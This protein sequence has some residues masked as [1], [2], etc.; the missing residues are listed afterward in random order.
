MHRLKVF[1]S[2]LALA[3][4]VPAGAFAQVDT[5]DAD[6]SRY[7]ALGDS[8]TAGFASAALVETF[9]RNSYP[10]LIERQATGS[11]AGFE[12]PLVSA[13]GL[14]GTPGAGI[15]VLRSLV[16]NL[17]ITPELGQAQPLNLLLPRPYDNLAVPGA[18]V[19]DLV[20]TTSGGFHDLILRPR[21]G[22]AFTQ[23][24]Q[25][26]SLQPT[27]VT[28]WIG[29]NDALGAATSGRVIEGVTLTRLADFERDYR[30]AANAIAATGAEMAIANIPDV[31]TIP[32]VTTVGRTVT[33]PNGQQIPL[34]GPNGQPVAAGEFVL[35][36]AQAEIAQGRGLP[37]PGSPPLSDAVVLSADEVATIRAR[38]DAFNAIIR[39]VADEKN[40]AF[41]D[42]NAVL[43]RA[44]TT[45]IQVGGVT[46]S[47]AF[48]T[49]GIFSYDGVHPTAFG[50]AYIANLFLDAINEEFDAEIPLVNLRPFM[51]G[52]AAATS[53]VVAGLDGKS[54]DDESAIVFSREAGRSLLRALGVPQWVS[55]GAEKP[56]VK[57]NRP[58]RRN[59]RR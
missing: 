2:L 5:G 31:T 18:D 14:G 17:S 11:N 57:P 44:A 24:Q 43:R 3:L 19:N 39:A 29:N 38:V 55:D 46:F 52:G 30:A 16:P 53:S 1:A 12:Q 56:P 21:P 45:G 54:G 22:Q 13:P 6:F 7:V 27:F 10:A 37:I 51:F 26:L 4:L 42:I 49:G 9:Q 36:T 25:G 50:Q 34:I 58:R 41:V 28:L 20:A 40:A 59:G 15:L 23:L 33:G 48:L 32:F 35:L 47:S 8:L